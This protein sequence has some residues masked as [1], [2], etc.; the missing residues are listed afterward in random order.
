[1]KD[2]SGD[3]LPLAVG[4]RDALRGHFEVDGGGCRQ[5]VGAQRLPDGLGDGL[6]PRQR[7]HVH[8]V[9]VE[10][11]ARCDQGDG[12]GVRSETGAGGAAGDVHAGK[13][14]VTDAVR[15]RVSCCF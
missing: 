11:V 2:G 13:W 3:S 6:R 9:D 5:R 15:L 7:L 4:E 14:K 1:M 8:R 12:D 10:D